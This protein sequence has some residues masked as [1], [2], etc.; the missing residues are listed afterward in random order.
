M[1]SATSSTLTNPEISTI[2]RSPLS[3][4]KIIICFRDL[5]SAI[6]YSRSRSKLLGSKVFYCF[7]YCF[8]LVSKDFVYYN[9]N[10][11]FIT[12]HSF[13]KS[14]GNQSMA[15]VQNTI[16]F[17]SLVNENRIYC[18]PNDAITDVDRVM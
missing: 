1:C 3:I 18:I 15:V 5:K 6:P 9:N 12:F 17:L 10:Y 13:I 4:L 16:L 11:C 7:I 8:K 2:I 14:R